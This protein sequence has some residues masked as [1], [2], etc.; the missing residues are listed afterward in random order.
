[1]RILLATILLTLC[2]TANATGYKKDKPVEVDV[3]QH[4]HQGQH[5]GQTA[6][7]GDATATAQGGD[8]GAASDAAAEAGSDVTISDNSTATYT[9]REPP[10]AMAGFSNNVIAGCDRIIG[11]DFRGANTDRAGGASFGV[12]L[13]NKNC[14]LE[15]A[16]A[17]AFA[18]GNYEMGWRLF[19]SQKAVW[20]G[21][22]TAHEADFG[23]RPSKR[24]AIASCIDTGRYVNKPAAS[25]YATRD[26]L[27][28]AV[29]RAF[30]N[31]LEK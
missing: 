31:T 20:Q 6:K 18:L 15:G 17:Q 12:P 14:E 24:E 2:F 28:E 13:R 10:I 29:D 7:G 26:E 8:S 21:Y 27:R 11:F 23:R 25:D 30:R 3:E 22:R 5:Q 1:M 19:C 9:Y 4:Q 16:T